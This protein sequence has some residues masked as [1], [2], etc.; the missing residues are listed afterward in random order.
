MPGGQHNA[1]SGFMPN[2]AAA[3]ALDLYALRAAISFG[4]PCNTSIPGR[5]IGLAPRC[6]CRSG[7][8]DLRSLPFGVYLPVSDLVSNLSTALSGEL[9]LLRDGTRAEPFF[10]L[11][12]LTLSLALLDFDD[13]RS[14]TFV[15]TFVS[16]GRKA[17][18]FVSDGVVFDFG[19]FE[20][21]DGDLDVSFFLFLSADNN[22]LTADESAPI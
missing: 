16:Y 2:A 1:A 10:H 9:V 7:D 5:M 3:A 13:G 17:S 20:M 19:V 11:S 8:A 15:Y 18:D 14:S 21:V 6:E 4:L 22:G 12:S